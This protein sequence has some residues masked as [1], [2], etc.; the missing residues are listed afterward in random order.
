MSASSCLPT[1]VGALSELASSLMRACGVASMSLPMLLCR[2]QCCSFKVFYLNVP[3]LHVA[4]QRRLV[5]IA[6]L[7]SPK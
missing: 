1:A 5:A 6:T 4:I 7:L 2:Y 3:K